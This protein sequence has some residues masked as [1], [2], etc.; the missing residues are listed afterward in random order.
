LLDDLNDLLQ[1]APIEGDD[2]MVLVRGLSKLIDAGGNDAVLESIF[3]V[4]STLYIQGQARDEIEDIALKRIPDLPVGVIVHVLEIVGLSEMPSK[5]D[6]LT[7]YTKHENPYLNALAKSL[8][9]G[10]EDRS[11]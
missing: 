8:L 5:R 11:T 6:I 9:T 2:A 3:N 7:S 4:L 1:S 10:T